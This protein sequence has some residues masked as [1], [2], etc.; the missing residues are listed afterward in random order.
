MYKS[1]G[2]CEVSFMSRCSKAMIIFQ[3]PELQ[4][5]MIVLVEQLKYTL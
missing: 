5:Q 1:D 4:N 2:V 3:C